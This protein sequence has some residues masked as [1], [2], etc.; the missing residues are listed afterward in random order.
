MCIIKKVIILFILIFS[1]CFMCVQAV[2]LNA[3]I[4]VVDNV[5][6]SFYG[7]WRVVAK[8]DKQSRNINFKPQLIVIWNLSRL[9]N[10]INLNNPFTG[11]SASVRLDYV[12]GNIIRFT[13]ISE[14]D[15]NK[16]L[17][18][19]VDLKLNGDTF[20]GVN[21]LTLETFSTYDKSLIKK[22][23]AVYILKGEK[24]SGT[25]IIEK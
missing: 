22:D 10:V 9:G 7:N 4:S 11:V 5:P 8:I 17:T 19:T 1:T 15:T 18:D 25:S 12:E 13:R 23:T 21:Y 24:L 20:T 14:Y 6:S 3:G 16:K 2:T